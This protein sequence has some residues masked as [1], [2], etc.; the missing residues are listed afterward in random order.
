M[1]VKIAWERRG[2]GF[3]L[4][5]VQGLGYARWG[6][7]PVADALAERYEIVLLDNR[8]IGE[9]DAPPGAYTAAEMA[10]DVLGVLDE[11]GVDRAHVVGTSLGGMVAQ[12][13]ALTAPE[14]VEKLVLVCATPGGRYAAPMPGKTVRLIARAPTLARE[15]AMRKFVENALAPDPANGIVERILA[16]RLATDQPLSAWLSQ[17]AAGMT[18]DAWDRLPEL[19]I[20][21]LV[22]QGTA[23]VVVDP[24]NADFLVERIPDAR[25]ELFPGCGH[26]LFWEEPDRFVRVLGEFLE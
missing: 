24:K 6:W 9:S 7:E 15:V 23:D 22:V 19:R 8:G 26:L 14:R 5:L 10:G 4:V 1:S 21:T 18:F 25:L 13:L 16:H 11:S 2:E 3:P 20:P 17:A 12:E